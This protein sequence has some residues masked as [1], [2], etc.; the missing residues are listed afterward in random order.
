METKRNSRWNNK[1]R[2]DKDGV[3]APFQFVE[4]DTEICKLLSPDYAT[5]LPWSYRRLP[6]TYIP[7]LLNRGTV[8]IRDRMR[9]LAVEGYLEKPDQPRNNYRPLIYGLGKKGEKLLRVSG[10]SDEAVDS[11]RI[12][13]ELMRCI[14]AASFEYGARK[15]SIPLSLFPTKSKFRPDWPTF[16][17]GTHLIFLEADVDS[18]TLYSNRPNTTAISKK[19]SAYLDLIIEYRLKN[20]LVLF[21]TVNPERRDS[22]IEVLKKVITERDLD[23]HYAEYFGFTNIDY[24]RHI[25]RIPDLTDW[26][27]AEPWK[28]AGSIPP[29]ILNQ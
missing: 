22:M 13:H 11:P 15:H 18:E 6:S 28:R 9:K 26:A 12:S 23:H 17:L 24:S 8:S 27:V 19:L 16:S 20:D 4:T 3:I 14:C 2:R 25:D 5:R 1:P 7:I 29:L 10:L 21:V